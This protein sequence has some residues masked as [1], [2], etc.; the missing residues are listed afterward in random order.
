MSVPFAYLGIVIVWSTT[1]LA[2]K[3]SGE[4]VGFLFGITAR[5]LIALVICLSIIAV[6][7]QK[8]LWDKRARR[9][10]LAVGIPLYMTMLFVYWGAQQIPS[11]LISVIFGLTPIFTGV[12]AAIWLGE[13]SFTLSRVMG[14]SLGLM[15]LV[16]IFGYRITLGVEEMLGVG[17]ILVAVFLHSFGTVWMKRVGEN[18]PVFMANTGG[19]II[20]GVLYLI[21]WSVVDGHFPTQ[22]P[23]YSMASI[24]YL[25]LVGSVIGGAMFYYALQ[26]VEANKMALLTLITP[27]TA[28]LLGQWFNDESIVVETIIG[29]GLILLGLVFYQWADT[30]L[31]RLK[32]AKCSD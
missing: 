4:H 16:V 21:T 25:S 29:A 20:A 19:L 10:Y 23:Q 13:R 1:P 6:L 17:A 7:R 14:M 27:V 5:V 26:R 15:G 24:V 3:W 31:S 11:G 30:L 32:K 22:I 18:V 2:I 9:A 28:L 8:L 12:V